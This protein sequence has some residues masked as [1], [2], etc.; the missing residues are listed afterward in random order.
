MIDRVKSIGADEC[1]D[2][3]VSSTPHYGAG[4]NPATRFSSDTDDLQDKDFAANLK[5]AVPDYADRYFDN[6]GGPVTDEVLSIVKRYGYVA[7]CGSIS[8]TFLFV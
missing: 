7:V 3:K 5:A 2:Y 1:I 4:K 8:G 6:V